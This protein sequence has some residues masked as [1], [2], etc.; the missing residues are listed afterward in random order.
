[1]HALLTVAAAAPPPGIRIPSPCV[2]SC[3]S[4]VLL[5]LVVDARVASPA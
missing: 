2:L 4:S 5:P 1:M 3:Q